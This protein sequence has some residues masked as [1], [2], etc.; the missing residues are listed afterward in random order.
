VTD[1][2]E[3]Y[4]SPGQYF[5]VSLTLLAPLLLLFFSFLK[6]LP[7]DVVARF[8]PLRV[9][10]DPKTVAGHFVVII[11][12]V[13]VGGALMSK[14]FSSLWPVRGRASLRKL[15]DFQCYAF[16][17]VF[18]PGFILEVIGTPFFLDYV[19]LA[20][21]ESALFTLDIF[22]RATT[23]LSFIPT[24]GYVL[25]ALAE[26]NAVSTS[27]MWASV[28]LWGGALGVVGGIIHRRVDDRLK[29]EPDR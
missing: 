3:R 11:I 22:R 15:L 2:R 28:L 14:L 5:V 6:E 8:P 24:F 19:A 4:L 29:M 17:A 12:G 13:T 21:S 20:R 1:D 10:G 7:E 18:F 23:S 27:R 25:P 9:A 26:L 16:A